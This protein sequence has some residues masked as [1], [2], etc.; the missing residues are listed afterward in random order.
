M[1]LIGD[2]HVFELQSGLVSD[3]YKEQHLEIRVRISFLIVWENLRLS[4]LICMIMK[5]NGR[6]IFVIPKKES[7]DFIQTIVSKGIT[8]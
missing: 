4:I 8:L 7:L 5:K 3:N 6:V 1:A 2:F